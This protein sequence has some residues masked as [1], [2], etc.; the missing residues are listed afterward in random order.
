MR[1]LAL[2]LAVALGLS[3]LTS[4]H[5]HAWQFDWA[6]RVEADAEKLADKDDGKRHEGVLDLAK[7]DIA[8]TEAHLLVALRD[9][10]DKVRLAAAKALGS[11]RSLKAVPI[12]IEWLGDLDS[13]VKSAAAE[14]L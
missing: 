9:K 2:G 1:R 8:L 11:G 6:G 14:A 13:K 10:S 3:T 5:A 12:L 7:Y 4:E